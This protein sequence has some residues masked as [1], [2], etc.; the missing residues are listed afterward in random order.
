MSLEKEAPVVLASII[1]RHGIGSRNHAIMV[2]LSDGS[3]VG[4]IGGGVFEHEVV[5][6]AKEVFASKESLD[7]D[8]GTTLV[9]YAYL[10]EEFLIPIFRK[11][12]KL[13][14]LHIP[15]VLAST[16]KHKGMALYA[17]HLFSYLTPCGKISEKEMRIACKDVFEGKKN[18]KG[19][20]ATLIGERTHL[21]LLGGG[22]VNQEVAKLCALLGYS[23][24]VVETRK[25][26]A[27]KKLFPESMGLWVCDT[28]ADGLSSCQIDTH[29]A[30]I[31]S[32]DQDSD[33]LVSL[34]QESD[35][36]YIGVLGS[37]TRPRRYSDKR[38]HF[39]IGLDLGGES[40]ASVA[41]SIVSEIS[42][43]MHHTSGKSLSFSR[44]VI[45]RGAGDLATGT[46]IKLHN[47]GY[48]VLALEVPFPSVIRR[49]VS[50]AEAIFQGEQTVSGITAK[51][52][53]SI[54]EVYLTLEEGFVPVLVDPKGESVPLLHP[55][56]VV[57]AI[58]AKKNLGTKI[59]DAPLV[60]ALGPGFTAGVDCHVVIETKR[61]HFLGSLIKKGSAAPNSG[62]PGLIAGYGKER[63]IHTGRAGLFTHA[64]FE[65]GDLVKEGDVI[66]YVDGQPERT[67]I[68]GMLR[69]LLREGMAVPMGFK[70]AD[71]DPR[72]KD[73]CYTSPSDKAMAIAG[74]VLEAVD[75]F[76][77]AREEIER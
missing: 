18:H 59:T 39:P 10:D 23:Y 53:N 64:G 32:R 47:A 44:L 61:D 28:L 43:V 14:K 21:I 38:I 52:I 24:E 62:I 63:V 49:T 2:L 20:Y 36:A 31:V 73:A 51:R 60:V 41:L 17:K 9:H 56:A 4:T 3:T 72:G 1:K 75:A 69:G 35:A 37:R 12:E 11:A 65:I 22:F 46:I 13:E 67:V 71:V 25:E 45:V 27:T 68:S 29:T 58:I 5:S 8:H 40:P 33:A 66:A 77:R 42:M 76:F 57:D 30:A 6:F 7:H 70:C 19:I 50:F 55:F 48:Q 54:D 74:G 26:Y 15:F 34:L 16:G